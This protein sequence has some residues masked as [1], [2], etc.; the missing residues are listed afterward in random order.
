MASKGINTPQYKCV[1]G[2]FQDLTRYL[3]NQ[4]SRMNFIGELTGRSWFTEGDTEDAMA[5]SNLVKRKIQDRA[6]NYDDFI[7][8]LEQSGGADDLVA[9]LISR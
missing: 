7:E 5:L 2:K 8:M 1:N 9:D 6:A 3:R 4:G